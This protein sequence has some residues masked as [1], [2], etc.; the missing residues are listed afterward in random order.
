MTD[1]FIGLDLGRP[2]DPTALAI[3]R[4]SP[5]FPP[6]G[7]SVTVRDHHGDDVFKYDCLHLERFEPGMPYP[8]IVAA[9]AARVADPK[10]HPVKVVDPFPASGERLRLRRD[11]P[12]RPY[13][14]VD[15]TGV[16]R[17]VIDLVLDASIN[18]EV[19]PVTIIAG[20]D[21]IQESW[22]SGRGF[23]SAISHKVP[24]LDLAATVQSCLQGGRLKVVPT[25]PLADTLKR[26]LMAFQLKTTPAN[27]EGPVSWRE[28]PN[29]DLVLACG[30][31]AWL[32]IS[33]TVPVYELL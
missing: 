2:S 30:I 24:R 10:L 31:A 20:L 15:A 8:A 16:G 12:D 27:H 22:R 17:A 13:L 9:V 6:E 29:E 11:P 5:L 23:V 25:L 26:E 28:T 21:A 1:Y 7:G 18:A 4:R 32:G 14:A 33:I 19:R 3:L